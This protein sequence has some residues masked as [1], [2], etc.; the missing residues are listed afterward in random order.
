MKGGYIKLN[1]RQD[2]DKL[3]A[4]E[5]IRHYLC[6]KQHTTIPVHDLGNNV[7]IHMILFS[8]RDD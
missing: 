1:L 4:L 5:Y 7:S 8:G 2:M 3:K 6:L